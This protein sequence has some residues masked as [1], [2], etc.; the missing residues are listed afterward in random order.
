MVASETLE[1]KLDSLQN[2]MHLAKFGASV[3]LRSN[4]AGLYVLSVVSSDE[5]AVPKSPGRYTF[6]AAWFSWGG[7]VLGR[8]L[9]TSGVCDPEFWDDQ[10]HPVALRSFKACGAAI[11]KDAV[12]ISPQGALE[13]IAEK[14][15][16]K[17]SYGSPH[18]PPRS[19]VAAETASILLLGFAADV[20]GRR[21]VCRAFEKASHLPAAGLPW[22][23]P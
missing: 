7:D 4:A 15:H 17:W 10:C 19:P 14:L 21:A 3:P 22:V 18:Q 1:G 2:C 13:H 5:R 9:P 8:G 6:S 23:F 20:V 16:L 12:N 11:L